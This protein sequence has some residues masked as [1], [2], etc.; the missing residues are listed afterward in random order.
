VWIDKFLPHDAM[1]EVCAK[2][3]AMLEDKIEFLK[4]RRVFKTNFQSTNQMYGR[5]KS[6][7]P[8]ATHGHIS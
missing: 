5:E 4:L 3:N 2:K 8:V 1:L 6:K 7:Q